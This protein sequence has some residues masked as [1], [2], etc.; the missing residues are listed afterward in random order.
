MRE[1]KYTSPYELKKGY[2]SDSG[3]DVKITGIDLINEKLKDLKGIDPY[4][5]MPNQTLQVLTG[6]SLELPEDIE[7]QVRPKSGLSKQG[8]LIHFGTVDSGFRGEIKVAVTNVTN[9][10]IKLEHRQKIAQ[11]V[12]VKKDSVNLEKSESIENETERGSKGFGST[13]KF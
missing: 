4:T 2:E 11:L 13:G 7:V 10:A 5:I 6:V 12:F 8:I 1:I 9:N 3:F